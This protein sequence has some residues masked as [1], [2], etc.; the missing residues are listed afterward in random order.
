[1]LEILITSAG[2]SLLR[3]KVHT[4]VCFLSLCAGLTVFSLLLLYVKHELTWNH[5][6]PDADKIHRLVIDQNLPTGASGSFTSTSLTVLDQLRNYFP[7]VFDKGTRIMSG[8]G[9]MATETH[10]VEDQGLILVDSDYADIFQVEV[11]AG[12]LQTTLQSPGLI[13]VEETFA[14]EHLGDS[15]L[16]RLLV[17]T[18]FFGMEQAFTVGAIFRI[19]RHVSIGRFQVFLSG[20]NDSTIAGI[21]PE[22]QR[23]FA[24][25]QIWVTFNETT[26]IE[27]FHQRLPAFLDEHFPTAQY[28]IPPGEPASDFIQYRFQPLIEIYLDPTTND[29]GGDLARI[30]TFALVGS[31]VLLVGCSNAVSLSLAAVLERRRE[32][33]IRKAI[34]GQRMDIVL[35]SLGETL[36]LT[37]PALVLAQLLVH[38]L[39]PAFSGLLTLREPLE[40]DAGD[41]W[42]M[43][44]IAMLA[45]LASGVYPALA[46]ARMSPEAALRPGAGTGVAS[47]QWLRQCL[48]GSQ[49]AFALML[50]ISTLGLY[51]QLDVTRNQP[52]NFRPDNLVQVFIDQAVTNR[53]MT[54][55]AEELTRIPGIEFA[56]VTNALP[57]QS[58]NFQNSMSMVRS[59]EA[60]TVI[61]VETLYVGYKVFE[62]LEVP[63][64]AGRTFDPARDRPTAAPQ[65]SL[66]DTRNDHRIVLNRRAVT[67]LGFETPAAAVGQTVFFR[68]QPQGGRTE[69]G[70]QA[71]EIIGVVDDHMYRSLKQRP[72]P[73]IYQ[74]MSFDPY[75]L[76]FRYSD[77]VADTIEESVRQVW[78]DVTGYSPSSF[79]FIENV[80][81]QA[82]IQEESE[83]RILLIAAGLAIF[84]SGI[85]LYGLAAF[86]MERN[87]KE[88]GVRKVLGASV[89]SITGLFLWRFSIPVLLANIVAWPAAIY[90]ILQ[91]IERFPYQM[92]KSWLLPLCLAAT[93]L[94]ALIANLTVAGLAVKAARANP[95]QSLRYE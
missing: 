15:P 53:N 29:S 77:S 66:T 2:R 44:G 49:F 62:L 47:T 61:P 92:D 33:G 5:S 41:Y 13:A 54:V 38:W 22:D 94:V 48:V 57:N 7:G 25:G 63:L 72:P 36:A 86:T 81:A 83:S 4:L 9:D 90:F 40:P 55:V 32:I 26:D 52:M 75:H 84:L 68:V 8:F 21:L 12:N 19:P 51:K 14:A 56:E 20:L 34:G 1:M 28:Q 35:L 82:F 59:T 88:V 37:L 64:L 91:W 42:L 43:A 73:E 31:L 69:V 71:F 60:L 11:I 65:E 27:D 67:A 45:G 78:E 80:L 89:G 10:V 70:H 30:V 93:V 76:V 24:G 79:T 85:G 39:A 50:L 46:M 87:T 17:Y 18:S 16:G 74:L 23:R 95:V 6:W 58:S 3:N